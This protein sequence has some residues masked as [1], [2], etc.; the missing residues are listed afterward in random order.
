MGADL[1]DLTCSRQ[2]V[3][4][5]VLLVHAKEGVRVPGEQVDV[6]I[7]IR[8]RHLFEDDLEIVNLRDADAQ[9]PRDPVIEA[10]F[11]DAAGTVNQINLAE[12][13]VGQVYLIGA[14]K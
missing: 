13:G 14:G 3:R 10:R 5:Q 9:V 11:A 4:E 12:R 1:L 8:R 7:L 2:E 6:G